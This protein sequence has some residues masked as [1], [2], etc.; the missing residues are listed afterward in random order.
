ML[1]RAHV[2][3]GVITRKQLESL[4]RYAVVVLPNVARMDD[5]EIAAFRKYVS[6]GGLLYAS[7]SSSLTHTRGERCDDF[8]LADVFGCSY[9][10][11]ESGTVLYVR[12]FGEEIAPQ[13]YLSVMPHMEGM[14]VSG[15]GVRIPSLRTTIGEVLATLTLPYGHPNPG[16]VFDENWSSIHSWPPHTDT[17]SPVI[18]RNGGSI[19]SSVVLEETDALANER[20]FVSLIRALLEGRERWT[21]ETHPTVWVNVFDR[22]DC[23][24]ASFV[25]YSNDLPPMPVENVR[26]SLR[27]PDAKQFSSLTLVPEGVA[28]PFETDDSGALAAALP[29]LEEFAM[30]IARYE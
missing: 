2:P 3:F 26:F 29:S 9:V 5:D 20:L 19:Y 12:T 15:R 8:M 24:I 7:G 13:R 14:N 17:D 27:A 23:M 11:E 4:D 1:Q 28:L 30:V 16:T 22:D 21:V 10:G 6:L 25:N 18:V